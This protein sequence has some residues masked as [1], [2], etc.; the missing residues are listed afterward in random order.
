MDH[1]A[2]QTLSQYLPTALRGGSLLLG[3]A[4]LGAGVNGILNPRGYAEGFGLPTPTGP[5][6]VKQGAKPSSSSDKTSPWIP[7]LASRNI[8]TGLTTFALAVR[9]EWRTVGL[10]LSCN[11]P[12]AAAD[13]WMIYH[14]GVRAQ[15]MSHTVSVP[16]L[17][18]LAWG[19]N[20]LGG[21]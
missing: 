20:T 16:L 11:I 10:L 12:C 4:F 21:R 5:S 19:L 13:G 2:V 1:P 6:D 18:L 14:R 3:T 17:A 8:A 15:R 9:G 7:I